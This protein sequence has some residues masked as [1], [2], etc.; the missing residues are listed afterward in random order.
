MSCLRYLVRLRKV[1]VE[2]IFSVLL[3]DSV[4]SAVE[5]VTHLY[6]VLN[7]LFIQGRQGARHTRCILGSTCEVYL[8]AEGVFAAAIYF[9][10]GVKLGM[11]L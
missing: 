4:D 1:G 11:N 6:S 3:A 8:Q 7:Y 10:R 9:G 5:G 2:I